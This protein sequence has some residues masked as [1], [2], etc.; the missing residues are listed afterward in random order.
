MGERGDIPVFKHS[1]VAVLLL[2]IV[3]C[4]LYHIYWNIKI[5]EVL[6]A[7][8]KRE[9]V[10]PTVAALSGCCLPLNI[11]FFYLCGDA[12]GDL[13]RVI[14][15]E[16]QLRGKATLLLLLGVLFPM[17]AAMIVQGHVNELYP[18]S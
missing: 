8:A 7:V 15:K 5:A 18:D 10:S 2:S 16:D 1:P 12:L 13:G 6:N 9:A 11:Y 3:T 14:G 17:V 4:G